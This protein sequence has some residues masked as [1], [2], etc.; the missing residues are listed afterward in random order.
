MPESLR[1]G[2]S[3]VIPAKK[4]Q[5]T[6]DAIQGPW[7]AWFFVCDMSNPKKHRCLVPKD[8]AGAGAFRD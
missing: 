7:T 5:L 4:S 8:I 2:L 6:A 1:Y 3:D